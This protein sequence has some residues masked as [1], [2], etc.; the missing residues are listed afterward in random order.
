VGYEKPD[1][2]P[3]GDPNEAPNVVK[4][5]Q[6]VKDA[7]AVGSPVTVWGTDAERSKRITRYYAD[8][9]NKI[10]LK[11][12]VRIIDAT[13]YYATIG[14][15]K[16]KA[17]TG[18]DNW[19]QDFPHPSDYFFLLEGGSIQPTNNPNHSMV[20]DPKVNQLGAEIT[21]A[22]PSKVADK[23]KQLDSYI[24]G[25]DKAYV[26]AYGDVKEPSFLSERMD[27]ENCDV[28][29]PVYQDDWSQFCLK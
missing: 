10:G 18:F 22:D 25:P 24:S 20:D 5:R 27:F 1:P 29:S 4:A 23:S 8:V 14:N 9:L 11:A 12:K 26:L 13:N 7:G 21:A 16:Y 15:K 19:L 3:W 28:F 6:L 17:Q 2:C